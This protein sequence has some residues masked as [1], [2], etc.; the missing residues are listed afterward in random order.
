MQ[1]FTKL[2]GSVLVLDQENKVRSF[3]FRIAEDVY[4]E[5]LRQSMRTFFYQRVG[6]AKEAPYAGEGWV[7]GASHS[8]DLQDNNCRAWFDKGNPDS[9]RAS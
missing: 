3:K 6:F 8:G 4:N 9:E 1:A 5:V 2:T 7:D